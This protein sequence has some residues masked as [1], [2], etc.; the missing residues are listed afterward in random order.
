MV[1][2]F[3]AKSPHVKDECVLAG[4]RP[5]SN[6]SELYGQYTQY[7]LEVLEERIRDRVKKEQRRELAKRSFDI[8]DAKTLL[9]EQKEFIESMM[10]ELIE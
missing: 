1:T 4:V 6:L 2:S 9:T 5:I 8:A 7:R 3:R 10:E